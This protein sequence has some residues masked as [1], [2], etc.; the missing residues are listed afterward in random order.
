MTDETELRQ[1]RSR[2]QEAERLLNSDLMQGA[3]AT[4]R[5]NLHTKWELTKAED[6]EAREIFYTQL[7]CVNQVDEYFKQAIRTG[8][9]A[10]KKLE[11]IDNGT[12][13]RTGPAG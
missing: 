7:K 5:A 13:K 10:D 9:L 8:K 2:G 1:E 6:K 4:I 11:A 3:F 12:T